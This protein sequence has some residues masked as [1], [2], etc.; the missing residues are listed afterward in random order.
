MYQDFTT[1]CDLMDE[2]LG[3]TGIL[4]P[5]I[6]EADQLLDFL[7]GKTPDF[8]GIFSTTHQTTRD[9]PPGNDESFASHLTPEDFPSDARMHSSEAGPGGVGLDVDN[10]YFSTS[11]RGHRP[12]RWG[13]AYLEEDVGHSL[14]K[15]A[16]GHIKYMGPSMAFVAGTQI[17]QTWITNATSSTYFA[18]QM[19]SFLSKWTPDALDDV[20]STS[21]PYDAA[22]L[23][24]Y[25]VALS[26][27]QTYFDEVQCAFPVLDQQSFIHEFNRSYSSLSH[28][29]NPTWCAL[30][31]I[32]LAMGSRASVSTNDDQTCGLFCNALG[33]F[34]R[35]ALGLSSL[36]KVQTLTLMYL[37]LSHS[38][39]P[40]WGYTIL[41][42]AVRDSQA[43]GL[44]LQPRRA[45]G[46]SHEE[47]RQR[48]L[49]FW[50][51]YCLDTLLTFRL[52]RAPILRREDIEVQVP[53]HILEADFSNPEDCG[54]MD[55]PL[56]GLPQRELF[57]A[58]IE[59]SHILQRVFELTARS[60]ELEILESKTAEIEKEI[61]KFCDS[62]DANWLL[63]SGNEA[64]QISN[65]SHLLR[66]P[67]LVLNS[68]ICVARWILG[69]RVLAGKTVQ[70]L[71]HKSSDQLPGHASSETRDLEKTG[72]A[73]A[74]LIRMIT[75][76]P[77]DV[78]NFY[79][80][81]EP[82]PAFALYVLY[83]AILHNPAVPEASEY[84]ELISIVVE[85]SVH[86]VDTPRPL[87]GDP[88]LTHFLTFFARSARMTITRAKS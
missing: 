44:H 43:L 46:F 56:L 32:V 48:S 18:D 47:L 11:S 65:T 14:Q 72:E 27:L 21:R 4:T 22:Y 84:M 15:A 82:F 77:K 36:R 35:V 62:L 13:E 3:N 79:W 55:D 1:H 31:N 34:S 26:Y 59:V 19:H 63:K 67:L 28:V 5:Q 78:S 80:Y 70:G 23:P 86:S 9:Q 60:L 54:F 17:G 42:C 73:A 40:H 8:N 61:S 83:L 75:A 87:L 41:A 37:F 88:H 16:S 69:M 20:L 45:W 52:G 76:L 12:S 50:T 66:L 38:T 58:N 71:K 53:K 7:P 10:A 2:V 6:F 24:P 30:V 85:S 74:L 25:D 81:L 33:L 64:R 29:Q 51:L 39:S 57:L 49:V 68:S